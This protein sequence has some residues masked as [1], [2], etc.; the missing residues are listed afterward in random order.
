MDLKFMY[1]DAYTLIFM[2]FVL[3]IAIFLAWFAR[4]LVGAFSSE[5]RPKNWAV[6]LT[7]L[8]FFAFLLVE[9]SAAY[10]RLKHACN[11]DG[12]VNF[13]SH[14]AAD[15]IKLSANANQKSAE[16]F[17]S[18]GYK[19]VELGND[20]YGYT[21]YRVNS[22]EP[23]HSDTSVSEVALGRTETVSHKLPLG[24]DL[25]HRDVIVEK[26]E[27]VE[28]Y[29]IFRMYYVKSLWIDDLTDGSGARLDCRTLYPKDS[30]FSRDSVPID[31]G[32]RK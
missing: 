17:Y 29:A 9:P 4:K 11:L 5:T 12:G 25:R 28:K 2:P 26:A 6:L 14:T 22:S 30:R 20:T 1:L 27:K 3:L 16:Q 19:T 18:L 21:R 32:A 31:L 15:S 10:F 7:L 13:Y 23:I 8:P 24:G